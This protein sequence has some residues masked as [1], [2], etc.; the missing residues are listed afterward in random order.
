MCGG[1][2]QP[3]VRFPCARLLIT[4]RRLGKA[5]GSGPSFAEIARLGWRSHRVE[6]AVHGNLKPTKPTVYR[7]KPAISWPGGKSRLLKH[8]L[9]LIPEHTCYCEPFAGGLAVLLAKPRSTLEVINDAN[10]DLVT[11]YRCVRFHADVLLTEL[12]FVLNSREEFADF[13]VQPGL[14]DIQRSARWFYVNKISFGAQMDS[15]GT[16]ALAGGAAHGSRANRMEAIRALNARLDRACIE[17]LDWK[18]CIELYDRP[19]T[20]F[21]CD[22]PYTEC[23]AGVY[24]TWTNTDVQILRDCLAR[25]RGRW[26]VTLN[27]TAAIRAIFAGCSIQPMERVRGIDNRGGA[28]KTYRELLITA[29]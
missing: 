21:F 22:P 11:F 10:G 4:L 26:V 2:P 9:P 5:R 15:F 27:D 16:G 23:E 28:S 18:R 12:E 20:F 6:G 1:N 13:R 3:Q 14:T 24:A 8:I 25:L 29:A 7:V 17:H 19:T